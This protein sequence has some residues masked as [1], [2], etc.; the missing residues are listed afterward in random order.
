MGLVL[1]AVIGF[2]FLVWRTR[3][4]DRQTKIADRQTEIANRN[5]T[6]A[7]KQ[8]QTAAANHTSEMFSKSIEQLGAN[9]NNKPTL[10]RRIGAIFA[11]EKTAINN[12]DYYSQVIEVLCAYVRLH[13][14]LKHKQNQ[15]SKDEEDVIK[16][17]ESIRED[18]QLALIVISRCL[19]KSDQT[20]RHLDLQGANLLGANLKGINL[21]GAD[22]RAANLS[23]ADL[24]K[25][26]LQAADL[27]EANLQEADFSKANLQWANL[28]KADFSEAD[29]WYAN[30]EWADLTLAENLTCSQLQRTLLWR[31]TYRDETLACDE[32]IPVRGK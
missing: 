5:A 11:L 17:N 2:P 15:I 10:E 1:V 8:A 18:I 23:K 25:A 32:D 12:E 9:E 22:L 21:I 13:T 19:P 27:S 24:R 7:N 16:T 26:N 28:Q 31:N 3:I 20:K 30:V 29:L 14:P 4:A 6:T